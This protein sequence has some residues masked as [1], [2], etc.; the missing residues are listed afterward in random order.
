MPMKN[1]TLKTTK[2]CGNVFLDLG[3]SPEEAVLLKMRSDLLLKLR[4][5]ITENE[6]TQVETA[7]H[8][9]IGQLRVSDLMRGKRE[10]FNRLVTL[11]TR[12]RRKVELTAT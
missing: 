1:E 9:H 7:K 8:L 2:S 6:W 3:F 12:A 11:A 10:K 4:D 5:T